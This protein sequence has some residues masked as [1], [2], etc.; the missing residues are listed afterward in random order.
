MGFD[1]NGIKF[2]LKA[3]NCGV[4]FIETA[5]IGRQ[6]LCLNPSA[7]SDNLKSLNI[8]VDNDQINTGALREKFFRK[9]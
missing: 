7:L 4:N 2:L 8:R 6:H 1:V 3:R 5:T 9:I